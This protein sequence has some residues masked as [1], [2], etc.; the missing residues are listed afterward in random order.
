MENPVSPASEGSRHPNSG[1]PAPG[2]R[3]L[4]YGAGGH[5][6]VV[7]D[8]LLASGIQVSG[9][10]DDLVPA[11]RTVFG[12]SILGGLSRL[13]CSPA[14]VVALGVGD[15]TARRRIAANCER[16]GATLAIVVHPAAVISRFASLSSGAVVLAGAIVNPGATLGKGAIVNSAA[17]V[18]HQV[19]IGDFAH[20][21]P[22]ATLAGRALLGN[23]AHLGAGACVLPGVSIGDGTVVG[24]GAVVCRNLPPHC[25][26]I[27][28]PARVVRQLPSE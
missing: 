7:L 22:N 25:V 3:Y 11:G 23:G 14:D 20:V 2:S 13:V 9:L 15:N 19:V 6:G 18:E 12:F 24:A 4:V 16:A 21:S 26:A 17:V 5:A 28:V 10:L 8:A 27:G 1:L